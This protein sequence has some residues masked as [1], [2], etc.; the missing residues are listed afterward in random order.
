LLKRITVQVT[1]SKV[2]D[3]MVIAIHQAQVLPIADFILMVSSS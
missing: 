2:R 1:A 3:A